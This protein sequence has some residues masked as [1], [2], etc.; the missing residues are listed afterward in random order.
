[1]PF[2]IFAYMYQPNIPPI[3]W[4]LKNASYGLMLKIVMIG[5]F[6][7]FGVYLVA[8]TFGYLTWAGSKNIGDLLE[9]K[10]IL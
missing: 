3:Y 9:K 6:L 8:S 7:V 2:V 1:M 10:N 4:E 5:T